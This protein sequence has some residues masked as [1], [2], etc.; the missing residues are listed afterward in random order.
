M[1]LRALKRAVATGLATGLALAALV[2]GLALAVLPAGARAGEYH[3]YSCRTPTGQVAP[4]DG[5][6]AP[7]HP[8]YDPTTNTCEAGGGLLAALGAGYAHPADSEFDKATWAFEAPAGETIA[9]ATLWRAG[10]TL[11]G[12]N[13][14]ASYL[15]WLSGVAAMGSTARIFD[16]CRADEGCP[17]QGSFA[18]PMTAENRVTASSGALGSPYLSLSTYCGAFVNE[19]LCPADEGAVYA[20]MVELF[21]ADLVLS[22]PAAPTVSAVGGGLAEDPTVRGTSDVAFHAADAGSGVYEA[23]VLLDGQLLS[24]RVLDENGGRCRD[25]GG[26]TDGLPAFLH[27]QPCPAALSADLP[28]DTTGLS[29]GAH[30]LVVSVTD[31]ARNATTVLDREIAVAN[32]LPPP[33]CAASATA[34]GAANPGG[35]ANPGGMLNAGGG[36][37]PGVAT[38]ADGAAGA[39]GTASAGATLTARWKGH[40]GEGLRSRYGPAHTIEGRLTGSG[41]A[42]IADTQLEVCELPAYTGAP[43]RLLAA[44][45]TG[46]DGRW[47]LALPLAL[48]SCALRIGYRSHP[49]DALPA[50]T[51]TLTLTVPAVL[52]LRI[53]PRTARSAGAIRFS[54]RLLG[55][56]IPPGG[57]QLVLEARAPGGRWIEFHVIRTGPRG[58]LRYL[59]RFRLGGPAHYQF[60]ILSEHE[61]D[62]PFA[63]GS[64]NVVRVFER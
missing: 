40:A 58:R 30:H 26:T 36:T 32:P 21:A 3:V 15:F 60:R 12:S 20:A 6:S 63:A 50:A 57:K 27:T 35:G 13:A 7:A 8:V 41:G 1:A 17:S 64:S 62:F 10:N 19:V 53:S 9:G 51:A 42:T 2:A 29:N 55:A 25:V 23:L 24:R 49:L 54:G 11:G 34:G 46:A 18:D 52:R 4:T 48:P 5:W 14:N 31:A 39:G 33:A 37:D 44:P 45:R 59:Y 43:S 16:E 61:A 38:S 28:L 47:S 56:P 22:Q